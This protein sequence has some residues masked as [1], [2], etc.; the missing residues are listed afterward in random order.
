MMATGG[1]GE[2]KTMDGLRVEGDAKG[3]RVSKSLGLTHPSL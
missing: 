3:G 2:G 1:K